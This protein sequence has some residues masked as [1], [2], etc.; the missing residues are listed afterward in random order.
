I[1]RAETRKTF[2]RENFEHIQHIVIDEAQ[3]FRTEDGDWYGKAKSI[4]RR[5][6]E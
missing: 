6:K 1:C 4:T 5:A 2:L 3:N